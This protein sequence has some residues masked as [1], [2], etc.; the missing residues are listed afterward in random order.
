MSGGIRTRD[1]AC[2][3]PSWR[4]GGERGQNVSTPMTASDR[5]IHDRVRIAIINM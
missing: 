5:M 4:E 3:F 2:V 1:D